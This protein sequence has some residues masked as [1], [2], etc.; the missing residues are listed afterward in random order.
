MEQD[1]KPIPASIHLYKL[2][3]TH[4]AETNAGRKEPVR[5]SPMQIIMLI[6]L[7]VSTKETMYC[8]TPLLFEKQ[9]W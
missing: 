4:A 7:G 8:T 2:L 3:N 5:R 9:D 6:D 1:I